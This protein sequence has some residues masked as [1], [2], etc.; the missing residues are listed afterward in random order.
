MG[1]CSDTAGLLQDSRLLPCIPTAIDAINNMALADGSFSPTASADPTLF[2]NITSLSRFDAIAF[3]SNSDQVLDDAQEEVF[4]VWLTQGG[5]LIGLHAGTACLFDDEAFGVAMGSWFDYHPTIQNATYLKL[6]E[7]PTIDMLPDRYDTY[8]EVYHFRSD[9]RSVNATV[10]LTVDESS[11]VNNGTSVGDYWYGTPAPM[12]WYRDSPVDLGNG[13][14][15]GTM[16]G[17]MWYTSLGHTNDT[18]RS[19]VHL[20]HVEAGIKWA[21]NIAFVR[22]L[23]FSC[24]SVNLINPHSQRYQHHYDF[25]YRH[26]DSHWNYT[27]RFSDLLLLKHG[28]VTRV[29]RF[30][31]GR[32]RS[33]F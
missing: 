28:L 9:P 21:L 3:L 1:C 11:Y 4:R 18:W 32:S 25:N 20:A 22:A 33:C 24:Q 31:D 8:E 6:V 30:S 14:N 12:A 27:K 17:R 10:L 16:T 13:T 19:S 5:V 29:H 26:T 7:H 2:N 15:N 23:P